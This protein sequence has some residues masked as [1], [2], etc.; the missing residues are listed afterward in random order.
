MFHD[1]K[2]EES[3]GYQCPL[4]QHIMQNGSSNPMNNGYL[5]RNSID[6]RL[7]DSQWRPLRQSCSK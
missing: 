1:G 4:A 2:Q 7:N 6:E 3:K 5:R